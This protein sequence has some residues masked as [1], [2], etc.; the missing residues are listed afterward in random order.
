MSFFEFVEEYIKN[1]PSVDS[2]NPAKAGWKHQIISR[3]WQNRQEA[4]NCLIWVIRTYGRAAGGSGP[5][6][7]QIWDG[8]FLPMRGEICSRIIF[9]TDDDDASFSFSEKYGSTNDIVQE[10]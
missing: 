8:Q 1:S 4:D 6:S 7:G 9:Y 10:S 3:Q 5:K 2:V